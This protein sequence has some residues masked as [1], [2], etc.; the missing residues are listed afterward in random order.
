MIGAVD[1]TRQEKACEATAG[2]KRQYMGCAAGSPMASAQYTCRTLTG[3]G[4]AIARQWIPSEHIADPA[5]SA[6][7]GLPPDLPFGTKG[8]LAID[9]F[10][11]RTPTVSGSISPEATRCTAATQLR[12]F[13]EARG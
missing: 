6:R 7:M 12:E 5:T 1:E 4:L 3:H 9:I 2:V 13:F 10:T 8:Q 11:A